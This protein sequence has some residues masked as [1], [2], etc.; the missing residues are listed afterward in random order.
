MLIIMAGI[1]I[2]VTNLVYAKKITEDSYIDVI[3]GYEVLDEKKLK[4]LDVNY[5]GKIDTSDLA[6]WKALQSKDKTIKNA[7]KEFQKQAKQQG[8]GKIKKEFLWDKH[9]WDARNWST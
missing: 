7:A 6:L 2:L 5:D 8:S 9:D 1:L 4:K 3:L